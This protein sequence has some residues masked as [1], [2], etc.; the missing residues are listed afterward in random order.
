VRVR[1]WDFIGRD[2]LERDVRAFGQTANKVGIPI[3]A[4]GFIEDRDRNAGGFIT[5][6]DE[7]IKV[8]V[9]C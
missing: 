4:T 8:R 9:E 3:L 2:N 6:D 5:I 1:Y 7:R